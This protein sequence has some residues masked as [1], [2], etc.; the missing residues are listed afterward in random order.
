MKILLIAAAAV[1]SFGLGA[2]NAETRVTQG[3]DTTMRNDKMMQHDG[4]A[5]KDAAQAY[6]EYWQRY[7]GGGGNGGSAL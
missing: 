7:T 6:K 2:A 1:L 5:Q 4:M 3:Q